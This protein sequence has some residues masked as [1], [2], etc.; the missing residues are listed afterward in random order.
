MNR[1]IFHIDVNSAYL[2]WIATRRLQLGETLDLRT[3]PSVVG[4]DVETRH[5]IVLAKSTP[6]KKYNIV[7][8]ETLYKALE[9][10]ID[11]IIVPPDYNLFMKCSNSM[12]E[13]LKEYSPKVQRF[14]VDECFLDM[15]NEKD[16]FYNKAE[17][18]KNRIEKELGFTVNIGI[19]TN[20]LLAKMASD[21]E[22]PNKIHTLFPNEIKSKMWPLPVEDLFMVGR[23]TKSK[24]HSLNIYTIYDLAN[25][26]LDILISKFKSF[27]KVLHNYSNGIENSSVCE[28]NSIGI[29]GIGNSI[30]IPYDVTNK[31]EALKIL[32]SLAET[33]CTRL[34][35]SNNI[36]NLV[37]VYVKSNEFL[38]YS[39]Q[40]KTPIGTN[41]TNIIF[42]TIKEA[43][44][45]CYKG[46]AIRQLGVRVTDFNTDDFYQNS[47][48]FNEN[49]DKYSKLDKVIDN[50]RTKYGNTALIRADFLHSGIKP[51]NGGNG[52]DDY[53]FMS[54]I[55]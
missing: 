18:I 42:N 6:A 55:L 47:F 45:E 12:M 35:N 25:Y 23:A 44:L 32:L 13:L 39:H 27:G 29:K 53:K 5:G 38:K 1:I 8:G 50:I 20:K 52:E 3:I 40:K 51:L 49:V 48:L 30:T 31:E 9:K 37:S 24:L 26:D 28:N 41:C 10:C 34:R 16:N 36:C 15:S 7:T 33:T 21:F 43:F 22:K 19:S 46:E 17:E 4:G 14:S 11:L 54:S 2:S